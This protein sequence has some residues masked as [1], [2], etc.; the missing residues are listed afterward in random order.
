MVLASRQS[1]TGHPDQPKITLQKSHRDPKQAKTMTLR[2]TLLE[3]M[4][5]FLHEVAPGA[6]STLGLIQGLDTKRPKRA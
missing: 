2:N 1:T 5:L 3:N 4:Y 6:L